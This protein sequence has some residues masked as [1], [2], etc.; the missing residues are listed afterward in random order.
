MRRGHRLG[1]L[2]TATVLSLIIGGVVLVNMA[3]SCAEP[4]LYEE[5]ELAD[6]PV[7][8][9][10]KARR[11]GPG[12]SF[13]RAWRINLR[14]GPDIG[15]TQGYRLSGRVNWYESHDIH[16]WMSDLEPHPVYLE[17]IE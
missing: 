17:P 9:M 16:V 11:S 1:A 6:V 2:L 12:L 15:V 5:I 7:E 3:C 13:G 10:D 14:D 8:V 4:Y